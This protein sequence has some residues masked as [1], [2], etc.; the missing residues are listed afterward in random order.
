MDNEL[1]TFETGL[2]YFDHSMEFLMRE[3][4]LRKTGDRTFP[5]Y[6]ISIYG[7]RNNSLS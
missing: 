3:I 4:L 2:L 1:L 5:E 7:I 6:L